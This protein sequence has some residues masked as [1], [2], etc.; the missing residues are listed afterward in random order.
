M[1][2]V[3]TVYLWVVEHWALVAQIVAGLF[4]VVSLIVGATPTPKDDEVLRD[5]RRFLVR[6]SLL[7]P[8]DAPGTLKFPGTFPPPP[9]AGLALLIAFSVALGTAGCATL[10]THATAARVMGLAQEHSR[11]YVL[12]QRE[13]AVLRTARQAFES[14][15]SQAEVHL[16]ADM[17]R[18]NWICP[19]EGQRAYSLALEVYIDQVLLIHAEGREVTF[20][21]VGR[22]LAQA[23]RLFEQVK[24][25]LIELGVEWPDRP[26]WLPELPEDWQERLLNDGQ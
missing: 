23:L 2:T 7:Q 18:E 25:C 17:E 13:A 20:A 6:L 1:E 4:G 14:G 12:E 16:A 15:S 9:T 21:E 3:N 5:I 19:V 22:W 11:E 10:G 26:D 8:K 24:A